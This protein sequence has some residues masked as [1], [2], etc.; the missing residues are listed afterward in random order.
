MWTGVCCYYFELLLHRPCSWSS[1]CSESLK[2]KYGG[3]SLLALYGLSALSLGSLLGPGR[4][5]RGTPLAPFG[6]GGLHCSGHEGAF[7]DGG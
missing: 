7:A 1:S 4:C 6:C 5:S 3:Y 2:T